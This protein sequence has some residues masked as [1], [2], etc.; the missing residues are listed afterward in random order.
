MQNNFEIK[1]NEEKFI[2]TINGIYYNINEITFFVLEN[3]KKEMSFKQIA[4]DVQTKFKVTAT[5]KDIEDI[6]E[7]QIKPLFEK[8]H[9]LQ[10][11]NAFWFKKEILSFEQY[12]KIINPFKFIFNPSFFWI[13]FFTMLILNLYW[14]FSLPKPISSSLGCESSILLSMCGYIS[15][16]IIIM[17]HELAHVSSALNF[18]VKSKSIGFGFY[19]VFPIF[20]A[21][22]TGIW[23][24]NKNKRMI[25]NLAGI[26]VQSILGIAFYFVYQYY[27]ISSENIFL[28]HFLYY[29]FIANAITILLNLFPFFKFDGYWCYSDFFDAPNLGKNSK[30]LIYSLLYKLIPIPILVNEKE[31]NNVDFKSVPLII[32]T[33]FKSLTNVF[34]LFLVGNFMFNLCVSFTHF[35]FSTLEPLTWCTLKKWFFYG[36]FMWMGCVIVYKN[37]KNI[38]LIT[39]KFLK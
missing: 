20:F 13:P 15:L 23:S 27:I 16:F 19:S 9:K 33:L 18:G 32:Y 24:L 34:L 22:I 35:N 37:F 28:H 26:Y 2:L 39:I 11:S 8:Q 6:I 36:L 10:N 5:E 7:N 1:K 3:V 25:V 17:I 31:Q 12:E 30:I 29:I 4:L 14:L 38:Y 21:D